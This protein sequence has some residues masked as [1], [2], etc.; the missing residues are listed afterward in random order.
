MTRKLFISAF[1]MILLCATPLFAQTDADGTYKQKCAMCHGPDG[2]GQ[3]AMGKKLNLRDL[4]SPEVQKQTDEQLYDV[5]AKGK[6]K[7]PGYETQ[8]GAE[9]VKA[10]V[11]Y[12]RTQFGK[13]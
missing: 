3:T 8:L 13:K 7:M 4:G 10:L 1:A 12:M 11:Q 6:G 2:K 9:R 5:T